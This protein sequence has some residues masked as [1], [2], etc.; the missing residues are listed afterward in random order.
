MF[1]PKKTKKGNK[2]LQAF[3]ILMI[4]SRRAG[5]TSVLAS[6]IKSFEALEETTKN[7][8]RI[9]ALPD[10]EALLQSKRLELNKIFESK[11]KD[12][13]CWTLD[14]NATDL[15]YDYEF[16]LSVNGSD[17]TVDIC[18]KDI[19]GEWIRNEP[20]KIREELARSQVILVAIDTPH[21]LEEGGAYSDSF[22]ITS[23][24][25]HLLQNISLEKE[26]PR[27][28]L[29]V[30]IKCEK[31]YHENRM[32][33]VEKAIREQYE[34][35]ITALT[36]GRKKELYTVAI[37]PILTLGGVVFRDF[38]RD[39]DG[40]VTVVENQLNKS[41]Y[42]RPTAA[43]YELYEPA[44]Y[45]APLYCE[46][47]VLYL[48]NFIVHQVDIIVKKAEKKGRLRRTADIVSAVFVTV[49]GGPTVAVPMW[50]NVF[51]DSNLKKSVVKTMEHIKTSGDG[52]VMLQDPMGIQKSM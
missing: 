27:M 23:D 43:Y 3:N 29:F 33:E 39:E 42:L 34:D 32:A 46:Q 37:T 18:F 8:F 26:R 25:D 24:I 13:L 15:A 49:L 14:E 16:R 38:A 19:P 35:V 51:R 45:F 21:L 11:E 41:L 6:M 12:A 20:A 10:T 4:G 52:Y 44:P 9:K 22:N 28:V 2:D 17:N 1:M 7:K 48:I 5:K 50:L 40:E 30:P 36:T 47:P 31:Y